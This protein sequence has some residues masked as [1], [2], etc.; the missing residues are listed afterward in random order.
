[1]PVDWSVQP[2]PLLARSGD[3]KPTTGVSDGTLLY[4]LDT[5]ITYRLSGQQWQAIEQNETGATRK[6]LEMLL[7]L[8]LLALREMRGIRSLLA[9][10]QGQ[11]ANFEPIP[12]L[13]GLVTN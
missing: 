2:L 4:E 12:E 7:Q 13:D 6:V 5:G 8:Q 11:P 10:A 9:A 3:P 1:M